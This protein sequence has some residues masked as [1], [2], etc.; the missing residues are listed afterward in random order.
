MKE[1]WR[2]FVLISVIIGYHL[3]AASHIVQMQ[4][5]CNFMDTVNITSGHEDQ[6]GNFHY[7]GSIFKKGMFA[8]YNYIVENLT[9]VVKVEPHIRGC[10]CDI[11]PCIRVCCL[12]DQS[13]SSACIKTETIKVATSDDEEEEI[14]LLGNRYGVLIGQ[15]CL[16]M[17][18]LEPEDYVYD[19]WVFVV[20]YDR[21]KITRLKTFDP[22]KLFRFL[23]TNSNRLMRFSSSTRQM[24]SQFIMKIMLNS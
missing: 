11:K 6:N 24:C 18:K 17:Y 21:L 19:R 2:R 8:T 15:P 16:G 12:A 20:S 13:N 3:S 5:P 9:E 10:V 4:G 14:D 22:L 1:E 23:K 7:K